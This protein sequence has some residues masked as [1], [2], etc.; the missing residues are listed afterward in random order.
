MEDK[1]RD[2]I[3]FYNNNIINNN[4]N[5]YN[6]FQNNNN[7]D[8]S[9]CFN[10]FNNCYNRNQ[11]YNNITT[12]NNYCC[13]NK[14]NNMFINNIN[15]NFNPFSFL[16]NQNYFNNISQGKIINNIT[17]YH[18]KINNINNNINFIKYANTTNNNYYININCLNKKNR[19]NISNNKNVN[20]KIFMNN[21]KN[22]QN[23]NNQKII[24]DDFLEYIHS[25]PMPLVDFLC[26]SKGIVEIQ[27]KIPKSNDDYKI[28]IIML[29]KKEGLSN[30]MKNIY[31]NYFFQKLIK[32]S[33]EQFIS[34]IL[35]YISENFVDI[36]K[37]QSGTFS[38]QALLEEVS[39]IEQRK[40]ILSYIKNHEM[41]MAYDKNATHVLKKILLLFPDNIRIELNQIILNNL[42]DLCLDSNGIC[43]IKN[44]IKSNTLIEDKMKINK[45]IINNFTTLAES[46]F[47]NYGIQ[48]L[49]ENWDEK[50]LIDIK[51]KIL[52][53]LHKLT[54]NQFS[55]NI[56]EKA[57]EVLD[58]EFKEK[59]IQKLCFEENFMNFLNYK[60]GRFVLFKALKYM[61]NETK[62]IL[63]NFLKSKINSEKYTKKD[64][65]TIQNFLL[66]IK[67]SHNNNNYIS[68]LNKDNFN[69]I[70][71]YS[72]NSFDNRYINNKQL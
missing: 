32:N 3:F 14:N 38:I 63:E 43:L 9:I 8:Y 52:E 19:N 55:S 45:E 67:K 29:I 61:K 23:N 60:Y 70:D 26:T 21:N 59:I 28:F 56:V 58:V 53:N 31:G 36:S 51:N 68:L 69:I 47:G 64:K 62:Q 50:M 6:I 5:L 20:N 16:L 46:P 40:K 2:N 7:N 13:Y 54:M 4:S 65:I 22:N 66:K 18:N 48:F 34:L 41:E 27:T 15:P 24:I 44:F 30:I 49:I 39:N 25:L 12:N 37:D 72:K 33:D 35:S 71:N 42:K 11:M 10:N 17:Q 57:I 1:S